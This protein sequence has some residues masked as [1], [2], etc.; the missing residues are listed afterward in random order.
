MLAVIQGGIWEN[1]GH[2]DYLKTAFSKNMKLLTIKRR[3]ERLKYNVNEK[4]RYRI[5]KG[6]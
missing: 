2:Q 5:E 1:W 6:S 4:E 3:K